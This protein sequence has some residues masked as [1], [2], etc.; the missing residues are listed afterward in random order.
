MAS[1]N[2]EVRYTISLKDLFTSAI[3][4][5]KGETDQLDESVKK[6]QGSANSL[7]GTMGRIFAGV[8]MGLFAKSVYDVGTGFENAEMGLKTLLKTETAARDEFNAIMEDAQKTPFDFKSLLMANKALLSAGDTA[9]N[10]RKV[11][12]D[13]ANAIAASG[14]GND[15][16]QRM[17]VNL[18]QIK[19]T[20][21]ATAMD[22]K[23]FAFAGI[24]IYGALAAAT[25]LPIEKVRELDVT[26]EQLS[27]ALANARKEG[28]MFAGGLENAMNTVAGRTSNLGDK[29]DLLKFKIFNMSKDGLNTAIDGLAKFIETIEKVV[30]WNRPAIQS[31]IEFTKNLAEGLAPALKMVYGLLQFTFSIT[32]G[33]VTWFNKLGIAGKAL[34]AF[35]G[36][37]VVGLWAWNKAVVA[38]TAV[39]TAYN[40]V[41]AVGAA[42]SGNWAGL[43]VAGVIALAGATWY[44][45]D[46]QKEY[47]K[48]KKAGSSGAVKP[49]LMSASKT[50]TAA[51]VTPIIPAA[52]TPTT[53]TEAPKYTQININISK[54]Q[55][56]ENL[57]IESGVKQSENQIANK[58]LEMLTG[59]LN[60]SQRM[61]GAH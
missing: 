1:V 45:I 10:A 38:L 46:A 56:S 58:V 34:I 54:M 53:K 57:Y 39:Q 28:G 4:K 55:A 15:E 33:L 32:V 60:D 7:G 35:A 36:S 19:N 48:Q 27:F 9:D 25:G 30:E 14:G 31:L 37:F 24:N 3:K 47:N 11:V 50:K 52:S 18:Q 17:V 21:K 44:L 12:L 61:A 16:L 13:L 23:Q 41:A 6:V 8:S 20:G 40:A 42:L 49:S 22:I 5:A 26:Y 51:P 43:A 59:A 2:N 29:F